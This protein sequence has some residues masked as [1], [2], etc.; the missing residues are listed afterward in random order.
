MKENAR[1]LRKSKSKIKASERTQEVDDGL[2]VRKLQLMEAV[3]NFAGFAAFA[4]V[5][6]NG[7]HQVG[8]A[9]VMEEEDALPD[10]P[11]WSRAELVGTSSALGNAIREGFA[12][13]MNE[14]V[15]PKVRRLVGKRGARTGRGPAGN[16]FAGG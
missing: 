6:A 1:Q 3:H 14:K 10:A 8:R 15:G 13:M 16:H 5:C 4:L 2:L 7:F 9:P 12:H 11:K